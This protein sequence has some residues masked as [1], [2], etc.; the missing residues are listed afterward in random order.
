MLGKK[1][2]RKEG[3]RGQRKKRNKL[4]F[5]ENKNT[6]RQRTENFIMGSIFCLTYSASSLLL[7]VSFT[8]QQQKKEKSG[9]RDIQV[10][11]Y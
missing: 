9:E 3:N 6:I 11:N 1:K 2:K 7:Y 10:S 8:Q 5:T 4:H